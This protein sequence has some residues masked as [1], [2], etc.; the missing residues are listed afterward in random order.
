[1]WIF[2]GFVDSRPHGSY[3]KDVRSRGNTRQLRLRS[4][5]PSA[6]E[7]GEFAAD[8]IA[9]HFLEGTVVAIAQN[10]TNQGVI[11]CSCVFCT[12]LTVALKNKNIKY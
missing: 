7:R 4:A 5:R 10:V 6:D 2:S 3:K 8:L 9:I 1:M 12:L 11:L